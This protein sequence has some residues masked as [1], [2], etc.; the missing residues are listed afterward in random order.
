MHAVW[1]EVK[2]SRKGSVVHKCKNSSVN[3]TYTS[4]VCFPE[5]NGLLNGNVP[6]NL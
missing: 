5:T 3:D 1:F 4:F 2:S 6:Q